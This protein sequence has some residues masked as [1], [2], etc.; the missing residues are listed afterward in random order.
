MEF[1]EI[2]FAALARPAE[3]LL[4]S[5]LEMLL[6]TKVEEGRSHRKS[7]KKVNARKISGICVGRTSVFR[8]DE[9][10]DGIHTAVE[11]LLDMSGSM[12]SVNPTVSPPHVV[13][14]VAAYAIAETLTRHEI[15]LSITAYGDAAFKVKAFEDKW[16]LRKPLLNVGSLGSTNTGGA[17]EV[18]AE[19]I[20]A[21]PERR[22][23]VVLLTDGEADDNNFVVAAMNELSALD[24]EFAT[25]FLGTSGNELEALLTNSGYAVTRVE[26][27]QELP[28]ALFQA[29]SSAF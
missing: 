6:E 4:G 17:L 29:I 19:S 28:A 22:R 14:K 11:V 24:V 5:K 18:C 12:F 1:D 3:V 10:S 20:S 23:M 15:P 26:T 21:R 27:T 8:R 9:E 7:G 2:D 13:A 16:K 25:V